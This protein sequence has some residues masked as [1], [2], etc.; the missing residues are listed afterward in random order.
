MNRI[1]CWCGKY[2]SKREF[3]HKGNCIKR[4]NNAED[5][6]ESGKIEDAERDRDE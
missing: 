2:T 5:R 6:N 4:K 1:H 3:R